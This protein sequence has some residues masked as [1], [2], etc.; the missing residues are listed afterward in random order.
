[1]NTLVTGGGGFLGRYIVEALLAQ[2][3]DVAVLCRGDYPVLRQHG[4]RLIQADLADADAVRQAFRGIERVFHVAS[5]TGPWGRYEDFHRTNVQGTRHLIDACQAAGVHKLIY[6]SSPSAVIGFDDL[7]HANEQTPY[8]ARPVSAYQHTKMLAEQM[9]LAA[10]GQAGLVTTAL[11][12]HAIWGPR[13]TQLLPALIERHK[14]GKLVRVGSGHNLISVSYVENAA[15]WHLQA[16]DY[17]ETGGKV[18]FVNEPEP[19][20]MWE[21]INGLLAA[22]GLPPIGKQVS[23]PTAYAIGALSEALYTALPMLGE[24]KLTRAVA[25]VCAKHHYFDVSAAQ[26]DFGLSSP[27]SMAEAHRRFA[28][29]FG[30][31][32]TTQEA[33]CTLARPF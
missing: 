20:A 6:T 16:A 4:V 14:A 17:D 21:W 30:V 27:V 29:W 25:A 33:P 32:H 15:W 10:H 1:M 8:P 18:Y 26:Q 31:A 7:C 2:G 19:V 9:V 28:A 22:I 3:H 13:D 24:P 11:R 23:Y 5:K 12:P